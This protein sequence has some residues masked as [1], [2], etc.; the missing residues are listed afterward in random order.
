MGVSVVVVLRYTIH[1]YT[2]SKHMVYLY[3]I[4]CEN[5]LASVKLTSF[6]CTQEGGK[7]VESTSSSS[8]EGVGDVEKIPSN[9]ESSSSSSESG[10]EET[11]SPQ[12]ASAK[13][14]VSSN[15]TNSSSPEHSKP[16]IDGHAPLSREY[17]K[18][19]PSL[20]SDK[21]RINRAFCFSGTCSTPA[22]S[23]EDDGITLSLRLDNPGVILSVYS[24][25][26][27]QSV[28]LSVCINIGLQHILVFEADSRSSSSSEDEHEITVFRALEEVQSQVISYSFFHTD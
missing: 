16:N 7:S 3:S 2:N 10:D 17:G 26:F 15:T 14:P 19:H 1:R 5:V 6:L 27:C 23:I 18:R 21:N 24:F 20:S 13:K 11:I 4:S 8:D 25:Y 9:A 12:A 28:Y 22:A